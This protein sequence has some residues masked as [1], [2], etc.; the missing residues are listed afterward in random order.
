M[1]A[2]LTSLEVENDVF[3]QFLK[4]LKPTYKPT[5]RKALAGPLLDNTYAHIK[6]QMDRIIKEAAGQLTLVSDS[7]SNQ[8]SE[9]VTNYL[10]TSRQ[11]SIFVGS[12]VLGAERHTAEVIA[13]GLSNTIEQLGGAGAVAAVT[14]DNAANIRAAWP[15]LEK[16]YSGLLT[17]G[18]ASHTVNLLVEN[19][20]KLST[21]HTTLS[22][23]VHV[24]R[25]FESS[26][27]RTGALTAAASA[28]Q[29]T[30]ISLKLPG[31]TRWQGKLEA[32]NSLV[33]NKPYVQ[34]V[35]AN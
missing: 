23:A 10:I 8:R 28:T 4:R 7:W 3:R 20:L 18:C 24:I 22:T 29:E 33:A 26:N 32:I 35:I 25:Y 13:R 6:L 17:L 14:T 15:E 30:R 31:K 27:V 19:I 1:P 16:R 11:H 12:E 2:V 34:A 21:L 9:S 5:N